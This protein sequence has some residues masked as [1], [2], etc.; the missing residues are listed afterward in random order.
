MSYVVWALWVIIVIGILFGAMYL[1]IGG[2]SLFR[3][4]NA[5][6]ITAYRELSAV[7]VALKG[8]IMLP[9][10]CERLAVNSQGSKKLQTLYFSF[11]S[12]VSCDRSTANQNIPE[13]FFIEFIGDETT[14]IQAMVGDVPQNI[15]I[16]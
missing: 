14:K 5:N 2:S 16:K 8:T 13:T 4:H 3:Q 1:F 6:K 9:S 12:I 10:S 15:T 7:S 11:I